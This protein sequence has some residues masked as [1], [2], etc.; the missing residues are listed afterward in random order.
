MKKVILSTSRA[1]RRLG[2]RQSRKSAVIIGLLCGIMMGAQGAAYAAAFPDQHA[3]DALVASLSSTPALGFLAGEIQNASSPASYAIYKSIALVTLIT[4]IWGLLVTTKLLRGQEENG[5]MEAALAGNTTKVRAS[6]QLLVGFSYSLLLSSL[7]CWALISALG[8]DP[9]VNLSIGH[10]ALLTLGTYTPAL[11]FGALGVLT[12]QLALTRGRALA[13]G[14][15][16]LLALYVLRGAANSVSDWN[17]LKRFTPFGWTDLLNPVLNPDI[18]WLYPTLVFTIVAIPLGLYFAKKRD[19]GQ[20]ILPQST[21]VRS[22]FYLLG[23]DLRLSVRQNIGVFVAWCA[24]SLIF[25]GLLAAMAKLAADLLSES[26]TATQV[27]ANLGLSQSDLVVAFMSLGGMFSLYILLF[28]TAIYIGSIRGQEAKGYLDNILIQPISRHGW[29]I[30]KLVIILV[31][32]TV[33]S[34]LCGYLIWQIATL[35]GI[36]IDLGFMMQNSLALT[37]TLFLLLGIGTTMYGFVPR[38]AVIVMIA[39]IIWADLADILKAFFKLDNWIM[40]TSLLHYISFNPAKSPD[41]IQF[42]WLIGIG[43]ALMAVGV[44]RFTHRDIV[45]E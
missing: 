45:N 20:S 12:S 9:K 8:L 11:F 17:D 43:I 3:R 36:S 44:W 10:A 35:Q 15:V 4:A 31:M 19:L 32:V 22:R 37:G 23:S 5:Q 25:A 27:F 7:I 29:L 39:I 16:P 34:L 24:G 41:W 18:Y 6:I 1:L 26:P 42:Y 33:I 38:L 28:M 2:F 40:N 30:R 13:Y 21:Y 14:L